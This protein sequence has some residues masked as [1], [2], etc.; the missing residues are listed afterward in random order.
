MSQSST[1]ISS[2][3]RS[4]LLDCTKGLA[5][6]AIVWHHLAFY[7]PMSDVAH[8]VMPDLLDWL[9]EYARMAVQIFLVIGGFL[10]AASLAPQGLSRFDSPWAKM[11]KR[12]VRLR[13]FVK[14]CFYFVHADPFIA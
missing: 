4:A 8:P 14:C 6:A 7:G 11:G 2:P 13:R 9:Y 10:A 12:F 3:S 5:C 1:S